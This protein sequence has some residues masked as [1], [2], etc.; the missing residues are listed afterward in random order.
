MR[1]DVA[2]A[3]CKSYEDAEVSAALETAV[4][5]AG[6][7]DW[8]T[9]GM[10]VALKLNLVSAMKPE[11]AATVHPAVV[12]ALVR[13]LQARGAHVVLGDSPGG[14]YNA[15]HLQRV[16]DVTGLRAAEA[17]GA[18]LNGDFSVCSVSYPEAVQARSFTETAYLRNADAIIDVCKLK[19]HGMM[20]MTNA[21][22]NF[23]GIMTTKSEA[24]HVVL[25][26]DSEQAKYLRALPLHPS[27]RET[28]GDGYSDFD[29]HLCITY[30]FIQEL[31]SKG[32]RI[33]VVAPAELKAAVVE[34]LRKS[35]SNYE[36]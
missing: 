23:F 11:E 33:M 14:L 21:V 6:G 29:Y 7:L 24:K 9:P 1:Y 17:L 3:A 26:A 12:C 25:R 28:M 31:L 19:T 20:G 32:S 15:A 35:L 18:E 4:T 2:L 13:M 36:L 16:Y 27:Q 10:R 22:K 5:A 34:E 8:V 30:D